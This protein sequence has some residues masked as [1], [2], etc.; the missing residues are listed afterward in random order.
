M[1]ILYFLLMAIILINCAPPEYLSPAELNEYIADE[2]NQLVK[3]IK[4]QAYSLRVS[5]RPTDLW[6][7]QEADNLKIDVGT[8]NSLNQRYSNYYYFILSLSKANKEMLDPATTGGLGQYSELVQTLSFR[9]NNYVTLTTPA[10]DTISPGDFMLH[11]T[12]GLS[13]ATNILFV[14]DKNKSKGKEWV[15]FNLKEFGLGIGDQRF[16]FK[17]EDLE[18]APKLK[19]EIVSNHDQSLHSTASDLSRN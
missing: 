5:Y 12:Y 3:K 18:K 10:Q 1:R 7:Y 17:T 4:V 2:E 13:E 11:R 19:F 6:I 16:R 9:M 8:Y 15:S 14:F